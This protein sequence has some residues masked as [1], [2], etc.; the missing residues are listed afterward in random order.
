VADQVQLPLAGGADT[1]AAMIEVEQLA[2][3]LAAVIAALPFVDQVEALNRARTRL[4]EVSPFRRE[5][6]DLVLWK[7]AELVVGY[8][9][10]ENPNAVAPPEMALLTHSMKKN[11]VALAVVTHETEI[12]STAV[13]VVVDGMHRRKVGTHDEELRSRL[14]GYLPVS[15]LLAERADVPGRIA[16]TVEFNRARG[17]H[18]VD[19]MKGLVR[20]LY[21]MGWPDD[22]I[23]QELGMEIGEVVRLKQ[24]TGLA[25]LFRERE[26]SEGW[27]PDMSPP[28][29][30]TR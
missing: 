1:K 3:R 19:R 7:L 30:N 29:R 8:D 23:Q 25:S 12:D 21:E 13:D 18:A 27:E 2:A 9:E 16:A 5:P 14:R 26:F 10:Y 22:R 20:I 4:H 24:T 15:R 17:T 11:G 28:Q 6:V